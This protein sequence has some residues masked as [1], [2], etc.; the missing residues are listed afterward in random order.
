MMR[1]MVVMAI[2][3]A[4]T[5]SACGGSDDGEDR[6]DLPVTFS[7]AMAPDVAV[8][9]P[10]GADLGEDPRD[11]SGDPA[12]GAD[13]GP[14]DPGSSTDPGQVDPGGDPGTPDPGVVDPGPPRCQL[15]EEQC[16]GPTIANGSTAATPFSVSRQLLYLSGQKWNP[17]NQEAGNDDDLPSSYCRDAGAGPV[18]PRVPDGG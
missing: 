17:D 7:D 9:D 5:M 2:W 1:T 13:T 11:V 8:P 18:L 6:T 10:G 3:L 15:T 14:T 4:A 16:F 12:N